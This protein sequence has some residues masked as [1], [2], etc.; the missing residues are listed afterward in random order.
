MQKWLI[1]TL[2]AATLFGLGAAM[3]KHGI[4]AEFP[5]VDLKNLLRN[6]PKI[7]KT[8][9]ANKLWFGGFLMGPIGGVFFF[10]AM[11][12]GKLSVIQPLMNLAML[13]T[14]LI[15]VFVLKEHL[16][17]IEWIAVAVMIIGAIALSMVPGESSSSELNALRF[18]ILVG[19]VS[20]LSLATGAAAVVTKGVISIE[21]SMAAIAGVCFGLGA[22][23][24]K[25]LTGMASEQFHGFNVL[26]A[27]QWQWMIKSPYLLFLLGTEIAGFLLFQVALSHGRVSLVSPVTTISSIVVPV[28]AGVF[29]LGESIGIF[30]G[31]G[32]VIVIIGTA[33]LA[34]REEEKQAV[35]S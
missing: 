22:I 28:I 30:Q 10:Q 23:L 9:F 11:S 1:F 34:G 27:S 2:I 26:D 18:W 32:V 33:L 6:L 17:K 3:Q 24:I 14:V 21:F 12:E 29:A 7:V 19:A 35:S 13:V 4:S 16:K 15:G 8:L 25:I 20:V 5:K 31:I